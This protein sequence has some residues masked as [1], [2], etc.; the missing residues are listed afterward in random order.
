MRDQVVSYSFLVL[1][2]LGIVVLCLGLLAAVF[3]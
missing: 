3:G 2:M 1:T